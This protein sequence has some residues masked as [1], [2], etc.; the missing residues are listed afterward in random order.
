MLVR[1]PTPKGGGVPPPPSTDPKMVVQINGFCGAP[2]APEI[3][4]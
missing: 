4:F 3:L 1:T 2:E